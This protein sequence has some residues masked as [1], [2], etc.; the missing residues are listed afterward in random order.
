MD[1]MLPG[2]VGDGVH[3]TEGPPPGPPPGGEQGWTPPGSTPPP[4]SWQPPGAQPPGYGYGQGFQPQR[5]PTYLAPAILTTLFCCLPF[6]I[7]A[8]V[9]AAQVGSKY[10]AGDYA[11]AAKASDDAKRWTTISFAVGLAV[12]AIYF[13]GVVLLAGS[14]DALTWTGP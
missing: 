14:S 7:V 4:P 9:F 8:I 5:P 2:S 6:G 1:P 13:V 10:D 12:I 11:G 3:R